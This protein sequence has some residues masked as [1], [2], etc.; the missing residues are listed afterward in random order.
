MNKIRKSFLLVSS[1]L[2][3]IASMFAMMGSLLFF[4]MTDSVVEDA[5]VESFIEEGYTKVE[6]LD[7]ENEKNYYLIGY[8]DGVENKIEGD[9]IENLTEMVSNVMLVIGFVILSFGISKLTL[10]ILILS[11]NYKNKYRS[12]LVI[13]LLI[14]SIL[15]CSLIEA[16]FLIA[17]LCLKDKLNSDNNEENKDGFKND[18]VVLEDV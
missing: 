13:G 18:D 1:I 10:A 7:E 16:G 4:M 3:I 8:E 14:L 5:V 6:Y 17:A 2:T 11:T 15:T 9:E 12:G